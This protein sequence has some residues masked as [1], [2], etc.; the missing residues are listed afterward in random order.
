MQDIA[1]N[2][3][4]CWE[5][6][7]DAVDKDEIPLCFINRILIDAQEIDILKLRRQGYNDDD[8]RTILNEVILE[9]GNAIEEPQVLIDV[10]NVAATAQSHTNKI[11]NK[12][13]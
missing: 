12:I 13:H 9:A 1:L 10:E 2:R 11:L 5:E 6:I 3:L 7:I 4:K 8:L